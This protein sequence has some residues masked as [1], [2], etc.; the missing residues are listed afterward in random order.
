MSLPEY[1][2]YYGFH[3]LV[4]LQRALY[5]LY[6][7]VCVNS[8]EINKEIRNHMETVEET[9]IELLL[10]VY[11]TGI[12]WIH[13]IS[14]S[15]RSHYEKEKRG[16]KM[17][18]STIFSYYV[19]H[20]SSPR[21]CW[22]CLDENKFNLHTSLRFLFKSRTRNVLRCLLVIWLWMF[23]AHSMSDFIRYPLHTCNDLM[24]YMP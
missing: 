11:F 17:S 12:S 22:F 20:V 2:P 7:L 21:K 16:E 10:K 9:N 3:G 4:L 15:S 6:F 18:S 5:W 23:R 24:L 19:F 14:H 8:I 13:S 1:N